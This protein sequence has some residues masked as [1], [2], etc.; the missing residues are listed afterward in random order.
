MMVASL[1]HIWA[2]IGGMEL[3]LLICWL[4]YCVYIFGFFNA[5]T[6]TFSYDFYL[7]I[8]LNEVPVMVFC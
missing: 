3:G 1:G 2:W 7:Y 4:F 5:N 6:M 8:S